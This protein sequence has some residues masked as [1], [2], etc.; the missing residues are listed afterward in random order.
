[1]KY[2]IVS[3]LCEP[4]AAVVFGMFFNNYLTRYLMSALNAGGEFWVCLVSHGLPLHAC[5]ALPCVALMVLSPSPLTSYPTPLPTRASVAGIMIMLSF[6]ELIPAANQLV[7]PRV[8]LSLLR[9]CLC[10]VSCC[11]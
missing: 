5:V 8:R 2:C 7:S 6:V 11:D 10:T 4:I 1:M 9:A 3:S